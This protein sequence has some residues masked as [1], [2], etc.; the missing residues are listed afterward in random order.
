M[1]S[2]YLAGPISGLSY[3]GAQD[4][5]A[6]AADRLKV[7]GIGS[8]S[9]LRGKE[10]LRA[11]GILEGSYDIHPLS[12]AQGITNRDRFDVCRADL[13]LANLY[14]AERISIGTV[15]ELGWADIART[16]VVGVWEDGNVHD[17]P[18][19]SQIVGWHA[20]NLTEGLD[21]VEAILCQK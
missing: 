16:P 13:I 20:A 15:I 17:H 9:P 11:M 2:V 18:M 14:G 21:I 4:W 5:R 7:A 10:Y 8:F 6:A 1:A 12:T 19:V 3:D